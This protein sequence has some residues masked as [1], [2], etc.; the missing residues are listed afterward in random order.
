MYVIIA[1]GTGINPF[2][3]LLDFLM[4]KIIFKVAQQRFGTS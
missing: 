2:L 1:G 3:D 4:K